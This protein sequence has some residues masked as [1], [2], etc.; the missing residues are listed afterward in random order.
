METPRDS[1]ESFW[2]TN[3][4]MALWEVQHLRDES[5]V[6]L[7]GLHLGSKESDP[8]QHVFSRPLFLCSHQAH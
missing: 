3:K 1:Q 7:T 5:E 2:E 6:F 4:E 8:H